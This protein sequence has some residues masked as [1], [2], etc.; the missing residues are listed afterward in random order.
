MLVLVKELISEMRYEE[1]IV[2]LHVYRLCCNSRFYKRDIR[3]V[4]IKKMVPWRL[5]SNM[6]CL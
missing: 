3:A 5:V 6:F 4:D 2:L 1:I